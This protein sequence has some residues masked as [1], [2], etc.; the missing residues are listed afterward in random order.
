MYQDGEEAILPWQ[1]WS[2][3]GHYDDDSKAIAFNPVTLR[4]Q[5]YEQVAPEQDWQDLSLIV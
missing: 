2:L 3:Y 1:R 5:P 4:V